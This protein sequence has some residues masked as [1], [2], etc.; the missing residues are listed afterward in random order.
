MF[1]T[2]EFSPAFWGLARYVAGWY[3][4]GRLFAALALCFSDLAGT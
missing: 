4:S 2:S 1:S 3:E